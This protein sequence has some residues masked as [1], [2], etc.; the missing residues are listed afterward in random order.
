MRPRHG[1]SPPLT[2]ILL[3]S[4]RH[5]PPPASKN[6]SCAGC[7]PQSS[8]SPC[9]C[10]PYSTVRLLVTASAWLF[11]LLVL[12]CPVLLAYT[13]ILVLAHGIRGTLKHL[14][15]LPGSGIYGTSTCCRAYH[16]LFYT[17]PVCASG[18]QYQS[19]ISRYS[20]VHQHR[21]NSSIR[22][23][24]ADRPQKYIQRLSYV[25]PS[26]SWIPIPF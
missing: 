7:A 23:G 18:Y 13:R 2:H 26:A 25:Y 21:T 4:N 10:L 9:H 5:I 1:C 20:K 8:L 3:R 24:S 17:E 15:L 11:W 12:C 19:V 6:S 16:A 22:L 14:S